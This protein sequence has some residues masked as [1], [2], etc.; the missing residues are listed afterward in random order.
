MNW[1]TIVSDID[2]AQVRVRGSQCLMRSLQRTVKLRVNFAAGLVEAQ[3]L[4]LA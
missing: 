1:L 2:L 4:W 3:S